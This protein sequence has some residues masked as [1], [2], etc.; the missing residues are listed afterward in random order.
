LSKVTLPAL[1]GKVPL[2]QLT[3]V[4][5]RSHSGDQAEPLARHHVH[6]NIGQ[7]GEKPP[8]C[9]SARSRPTGACVMPASKAADEAEIRW[10]RA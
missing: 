9:L 1:I 7:R 10:G 3:S 4:S 2:M 5:C 8:N 6:R